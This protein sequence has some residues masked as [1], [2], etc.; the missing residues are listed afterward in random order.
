MT[1]S[2]SDSSSAISLARSQFSPVPRTGAYQDR[3]NVPT[4]KGRG[5]RKASTRKAS[6]TTRPFASNWI[7][8][9]KVPI[10]EGSTTEELP[11]IHSERGHTN[12]HEPQEY[13]SQRRLPPTL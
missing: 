8:F 3:I 11:R 4:A 10:Q 12:R 13:F 7:G 6:R 9:C 5:T 1:D 2:A